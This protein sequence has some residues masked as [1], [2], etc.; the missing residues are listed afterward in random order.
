M[1]FGDVAGIICYLY[2]GRRQSEEERDE[3][4]VKASAWKAAE[5]ENANKTQEVGEEE[6]E[7]ERNEKNAEPNAWNAAEETT[8]KATLAAPPPTAPF[9]PPPAP[10]PAPS[11][12]PGPT[13]APAPPPTVGHLALALAISC[14]AVTLG[15]RLAPPG[16]APHESPVHTRH[17]LLPVQWTLVPVW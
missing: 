9:A 2:P 10:A 13:P 16:R 12:A 17:I 11:P 15:A 6:E 3:Q 4:K 8:T 1:L 5:E 14:L 7:E